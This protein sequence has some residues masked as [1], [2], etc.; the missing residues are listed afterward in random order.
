MHRGDI[1]IQKSVLA[2]DHILKTDKHKNILSCSAV[3]ETILTKNFIVF[4]RTQEIPLHQAG[5]NGFASVFQE[6]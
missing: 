6:E 5:S 3:N 4:I 1:W 2:L